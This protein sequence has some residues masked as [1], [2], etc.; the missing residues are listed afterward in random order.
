MF[1]RKRKREKISVNGRQSTEPICDEKPRGD[2][3]PSALNKTKRR[4]ANDIFS[5]NVLNKPSIRRHY[6]FVIYC[7]VLVLIYMG[8]R[9]SCQRLQREEISCQMELQELRATSLLMSTER[10]KAVSHD[11]LTREIERRSL[12]IRQW[13]TLPSVIKNDNTNGTTTEKK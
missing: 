4:S 10:I 11:N 7:C 1:G 8:Y 2:V 3:T 12:G 5:G 6:P 9:F 13:N